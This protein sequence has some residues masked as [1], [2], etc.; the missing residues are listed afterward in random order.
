MTQQPE[1]TDQP[2]DLDDQQQAIA[3]VDEQLDAESDGEGLGKEAGR[4]E[5]TGIAQG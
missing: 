3:E 2:E 1:H 5:E 4:G